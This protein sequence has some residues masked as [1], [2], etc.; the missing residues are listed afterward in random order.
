LREHDDGHPPA[1]PEVEKAIAR[2][3]Q[4]ALAAADWR[5]NALRG[6]IAWVLQQIDA[7][8]T[9]LRAV[10]EQGNE[11]VRND[12]IAAIGVLGS[13]FSEMRFL[14]SDVAQ[15]AAEMQKSLDE[16]GADIRAIREQ[17]ARQS[18]DIRLVREDLAVIAG[19]AGGARSGGDGARWA[20]G[21]P[22][23]G[24]AALRRV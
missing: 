13:D 19:R 2:Q 21:C 23:P 1:Q 10:M 22:Y 8:G 4:Q 9:A 16:Q 20:R 11:R 17:N 24:V 12:V 6:E 18:T 15:A 7:G 5:A 3:N 14:L